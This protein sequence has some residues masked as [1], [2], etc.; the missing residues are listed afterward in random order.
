[1]HSGD[2]RVRQ[3]VHHSDAH[4]VVYVAILRQCYTNIIKAASSHLK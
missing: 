3:A 4:P 2:D 1:M